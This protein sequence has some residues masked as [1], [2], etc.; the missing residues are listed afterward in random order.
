L[1][2]Q[3]REVQPTGSNKIHNCNSSTVAHKTQISGIFVHIYN[4]N[5]T[6]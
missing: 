3:Y 1:K 6:F 4:T 2:T 5:E